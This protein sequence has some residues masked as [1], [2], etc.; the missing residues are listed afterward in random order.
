[1][2]FK[3]TLVLVNFLVAIHSYKIL[4]LFP[5]PGKSHVDVFLPLTKALA[6]KGHQLTVVSHFPLATP[7]PNYTDVRLGN[8]STPLVDVLDLENFQGQHEN[9]WL[10]VVI[11]TRLAQV[12]CECAYQSQPLQ[13]LLNKNETFDVVVAEFFNTN[14]HL[15]LLYKFKAP[16]I[17]ISS[18]T[19]MH[20]TNERFGNP[21]HPAYIPVNSM[22]FSDR[23]SFLERVENLIVGLVHG[24]F[25][26][27]ITAKN[28]QQIAR[29]YLGEELPLLR[30]VVLNSSLL[31]VNSH[32]SLN[33]PRPLVP[34]VVEVGGVHIGDLKRPPKNLEKWINESAHGVIYFS[35]GSMIKGHTFPDEKRREFL[36]AFGRLPQR[37][38]WK[39][40]N[41]SM[42]GKPDNVMI[43]KWMPQLDILCHPNVVGF[44]SHGGLLGTIE[45]VH[46]GVPA[47]VMPQY[48]DQHVNARALEK[49][50]GGVIL[51]L[52]EATEEKVYEALQT[53]LDPK[54]RKRAQELSVRF[55]DRPLPPL[56]TA[57][58][59]VEYVAR[60]GGGHHMR[61]AAVDMPLYKYL[62]LDVI[63][64]LLLVIGAAAYVFS[65]VVKI[66]FRKLFGRRDKQK[67][68]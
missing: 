16:L 17:G 54:F 51:H 55:R 46:C 63:A 61:T 9:M 39:W 28:D 18:S 2:W 30:D 8:V 48:G 12:T 35:L 59:W 11:L 56:E 32:F 34:A 31:L 24:E 42:P 10:E 37:V 20:W 1:M 26:E 29:K 7:I 36:K 43:Q 60:H 52:H 23:M 38:L 45:A 14:C 25:F 6:Q 67:T 5:H 40:E 47:V 19:I 49:N 44:I 41:D 22:N 62:L 65:L 50:G 68:N 57:I 21:T 58:Y 27:Q 33:L 13:E 15:G 4:A 66:V 3:V 53:V 64:F